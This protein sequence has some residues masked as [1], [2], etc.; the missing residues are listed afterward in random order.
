M[1]GHVPEVWI[2]DRYAA[3]QNRTARGIRPVW[4]I[5]RATPLSRWS[6]ARTICRCGSSSG[7]A[8]RLIWPPTS[9]TSP[10]R[11]RAEKAGAGKSTRRPSRPQPTDC[12]L[13]LEPAG[14]NRPGARPTSDLLR[15][16]RRGRSHQQRLGTKATA[17]RD[18]AKGHQRLSRH[19]GR[20]GRGRRADDRRHR[21][22]Q[23]RKPLPDKATGSFR[24][25]PPEVGAVCGNSASTDLRGGRSAK[26][27]PTANPWRAF[28]SLYL[29]HFPLM[30]F[31]LG[32]LYAT[33][34]F[35][36]SRVGNCRPTS[37]G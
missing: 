28:Y 9:P 10:R 12:D 37:K 35:D 8:G 25:Q 6:M 1:G 19:V 34:Q 36:A 13:A 11:P 21:K 7:S 32:A 2:S 20:A 30:L 27:A 15:L 14:Q 33:G 17:L 18:P 31:I 3:Q 22:A 26:S 29:I 16:S 5:W 24:R 4:R 23:G